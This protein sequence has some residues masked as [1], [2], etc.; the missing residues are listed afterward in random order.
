MHTLPYTFVAV[1]ITI[2][3]ITNTWYAG[4]VAK[5]PRWMFNFL[6]IYSGFVTFMSALKMYAEFACLY[7][8]DFGC[9]G[10][11]PNGSIPLNIQTAWIVLVI[12]MQL[13]ISLMKGDE[14]G[15][16]EISIRMRDDPQ[17]L[18]DEPENFW[19]M[20]LD[21]PTFCWVLQ[22][23]IIAIWFAI[24]VDD[25]LDCSA[26]TNTSGGWAVMR[27]FIYIV[28]LIILAACCIVYRRGGCCCLC[29]KKPAPE[30]PS[31]NEKAKEG[32][33]L[34]TEVDVDVI[35][36]AIQ[37][38]SF[39]QARSDA[40]F[41]P[42]PS[43]TKALL[44]VSQRRPISNGAKR[45]S[46]NMRWLEDHEIELEE[47]KNYLIKPMFIVLFFIFLYATMQRLGEKVNMSHAG[48]AMTL[49]FIGKIVFGCYVYNWIQILYKQKKKWTHPQMLVLYV[50]LGWLVFVSLVRVIAAFTGKFTWNYI[51]RAKC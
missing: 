33:N 13:F 18:H 50:L 15:N 8:A 10:I 51:G 48:S 1:G 17:S 25:I 21:E 32:D 28:N 45:V 29:N 42:L 30:I 24:P 11:S 4:V 34:K 3:V 23:F 47:T 16:L 6:C 31:D 49:C 39:T 20:L 43:K 44:E 14:T 22:T 5:V 46:T 37:L 12:P 41:S 35:Q 19:E 2:N 40:A 26:V 9:Y 38:G 27:S 7:E 36:T